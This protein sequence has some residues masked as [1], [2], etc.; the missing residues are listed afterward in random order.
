[1]QRLDVQFSSEDSL[2]RAWLYLPETPKPAPVIVMAHGLGGTRAARLDVYAD[3]FRELGY[4]CLVFDYRYFGDSEGE[5]RQLLDVN[6]QLQDWTA[7]VAFART[8]KD[9]DGRRVVLWGTSFSGGHVLS[10]AADD[11]RIAAIISQC[12]FT[13]GMA[14]SMAVSPKTAVKVTIQAIKDQIGSWCG[15]S[16]VMIA[17]V[18]KPGSTAMMTAPDC[19]SGYLGLVPTEDAARSPNY[20]AAR[21]ALQILFYFPGR[22]TPQIHCPVLFCVCEND[23]VAPAGATLRHARRTPQGEISIYK[24]G[25]FD[26][27][28]GESYERA[29]GAQIDFLQ[30]SVPLK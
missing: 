9:V 21:I 16:P 13:D 30:R 17:I 27:Y 26:I 18:G 8:R 15:A 25:H 1:M 20:V 11:Q 23:S 12:P 2:C 4:A 24:E 6:K 29:I 22:K 19:E 7:A 5:P 3:R 14:S 28:S 10:I